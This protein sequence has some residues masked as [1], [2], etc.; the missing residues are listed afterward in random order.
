MKVKM[1]PRTFSKVGDR[2]PI[3]TISYAAHH[4]EMISSWL[5]FDLLEWI[6]KLEESTG[7]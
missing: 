6:K 1:P 2:P 5:V 7:S 3:E 4:A